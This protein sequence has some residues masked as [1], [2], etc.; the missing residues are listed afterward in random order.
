MFPGFQCSDQWNGR[1]I[2]RSAGREISPFWARDER[3][4]D[5]T[6]AHHKLREISID[7]GWI[8]DPID[9][10]ERS[11]LQQQ[12]DMQLKSSA[13]MFQMESIEMV[14][15]FWNMRARIIKGRSSYSYRNGRFRSVKLKLQSTTGRVYCRALAKQT[16]GLHSGDN[17]TGMWQACYTASVYW[18]VGA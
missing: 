2:N 18:V 10:C 1:R 13:Q 16:V 12:R 9:G 7:G 6:F 4:R 3:R 14:H 11:K 5:W 15:C 17:T 8:L